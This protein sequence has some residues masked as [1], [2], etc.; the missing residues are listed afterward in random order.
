MARSVVPFSQMTRWIGLQ[1]FLKGGEAPLPPTS[2]VRR[3][4]NKGV[5]RFDGA[6]DSVCKSVY[7]K[8]VFLDCFELTMREGKSS[9]DSPGAT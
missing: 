4:V 9:R 5:G 6:F 1:L 8:G 2:F 3:S 7:F